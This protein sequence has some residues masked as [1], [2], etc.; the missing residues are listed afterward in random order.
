MNGR[1]EQSAR[2]IVATGAVELTVCGVLGAAR[3]SAVMGWLWGVCGCMSR[4]MR[5]PY[6][7][8]AVLV[9]VAGLVGLRRP[10]GVVRTM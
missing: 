4:V 7:G 6:A 2:L 8:V 5:H 3:D 9:L 10:R 1:G